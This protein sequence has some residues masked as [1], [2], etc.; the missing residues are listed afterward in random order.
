M[1]KKEEFNRNFIASMKRIA[2]N[3]AP[4]VKERERLVKEIEAKQA[5][6]AE[7]NEDI[8]GEETSI[9]RKTGYG[10]MDLIKRE[11]VDTGKVDKKTGKP[12]KDTQFNLRYPDTILPPENEGDK[13]VAPVESEL[14][15]MTED[16]MNPSSEI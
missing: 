8:A 14:P 5:R 11:V 13:E 7:L 16:V 12:I 4:K 1:A 9:R 10:V 3:V 2:R 6:I 15:F